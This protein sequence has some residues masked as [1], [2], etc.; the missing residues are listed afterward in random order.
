MALHHA[1]PGEPVDL[2]PLGPNLKHAK[3]AAIV[4][5]DRFEAIHL[6]V[7]AGT[8]IPSHEVSGNITMRCLEGRVTLGL[9]QSSIELNA[10]EWV[11]LDGGDPRGRSRPPRRQPRL[12]QSIDQ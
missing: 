5:S 1:K 2:R 3:T 10:G 7:R 4:K 9:A 6:I 11:Y 8:E 12:R